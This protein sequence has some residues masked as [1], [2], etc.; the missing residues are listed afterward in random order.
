MWHSV[1]L[2]DNR[3]D[4]IP[5]KKLA[6]SH[7][8]SETCQQSKPVNPKDKATKEDITS[9]RMSLKFDSVSTL[10]SALLLAPSGEPSSSNELQ[11]V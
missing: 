10:S 6:L 4:G 1:F 9:S 3:N 11:P 2:T 7:T 5:V 8:Q